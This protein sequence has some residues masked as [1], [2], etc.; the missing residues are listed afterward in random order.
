MKTIQDYF[1]LHSKLAED[2]AK[3]GGF[4][5]DNFIT[6]KQIPYPRNSIQS[7]RLFYALLAK[8]LDARA[9]DKAAALLWGRELFSPHASSVS[10]I[11]SALEANTENLIIGAA[12][13]GKSYTP[14]IW[15]VL[16]WLCDPQ[17]TA[18]KVLSSTEAHAKR[19]VFAHIKNLHRQSILQLPGDVKDTRI[20]VG[21]DDKMGIQLMTVPPGEEGRGRLR[22]FHP[23]PRQ[24]PH[25]RYGPLT[26]IRV[27][28]DEAEEIPSG[29]WEEIDNILITRSDNMGIKVIAMTNPKDRSSKFGQR[30]EPEDGWGS[31]SIDEST[32]WQ[33]SGNA[34]VTRLDGARCENVMT[35]VT[36]HH[37]LLSVDGYNKFAKNP[38]SPEYFT[39]AR[40]WFPETGLS[41]RII[42]EALFTSAIRAFNF[43][44]RAQYFLSVDLAFEGEDDVI[45]G[46]FRVGPVSRSE[47][48]PNKPYGV[49]LVTLLQVNKHCPYKQS[50]PRYKTQTL[51]IA[52]EVV[53][54]ARE[55]SVLP[56]SLIVDRTGSGTGVDDV[57]KQLLGPEV[58]GINY[59]VSSTPTKIFSEDT[60]TCEER[61]DRIVTEMM[62]TL[63]AWLEHDIL[64]INPACA[65]LSRLRSELTA[66]RFRTVAGGKLRVESKA[67][68]KSRGNV[69]PDCG[70]TVMMGAWHIRMRYDDL[71]A[72]LALSGVQDNLYV[73]KS[74]VSEESPYVQFD[75]N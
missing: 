11:W 20:A 39:M 32:S 34:V 24:Q 3:A 8:L 6:D 68:Y 30:C 13:M 44:D 42:D 1:E 26:R 69:S 9:F 64:R 40:G 19:N 28:L 56:A 60:Q 21:E 53:R 67:E 23:S 37:G 66:R 49:E 48:T 2:V 12:A 59:S 7:L 43:T 70:D 16:D 4:F 75:D 55:L 22:G 61:Y 54:L 71:P 51:W 65:N 57:L 52:D 5:H 58:T 74:Q 35:G 46:L 18:V 72:M 45:A 25:P 38:N 10:L 29:A 62:F 15:I 73:L 33:T 50:D 17:L 36:I 47:P 14:G 31:V 27:V 41:M 63:R